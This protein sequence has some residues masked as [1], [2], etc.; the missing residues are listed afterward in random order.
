MRCVSRLV[1][2]ANVVASIALLGLLVLPAGASAKNS[3][4]LSFSPSPFDFGPVT[5]GSSQ[6]KTLTLR[7]AGGAASGTLKVSLSRSDA[8][9]ITT[10][11]CTAR[12]L[13]PRQSCGVTVR[14]AP[15]GA[16]AATATLTAIGENSAPATDVLSGTV[17]RGQ[18]YWTNF[19]GTVWTAGLDG[20]NPTQIVSPE[21]YWL[22]H[23]V[24]VDGSHIY[25]T[26]N[27]N[28]VIWE[29]GLDG[30]NPS[31]VVSALSSGPL[32][33]AVDSSHLYWTDSSGTIWEAGLD[34][35]NRTQIFNGQNSEFGVAVD[36]GHLYWTDNVDGTIWKAGLDG[37][38]PTEIVNG[39]NGPF[40]MAVDS[41][42]LYWTDNGDGTI[43]KAGL[44]GS[45]PTQ[46][47]N[48]QNGPFGMA[49]DSSHLYWTDN[50]DGT[51]WEAG[52]DG[53]NP[54][55][56]INGACCP[57]GVAVRS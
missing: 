38:H 1:N 21:T 54:T 15:I 27:G 2:Y 51:I 56:I 26:D 22:W 30:S 14:F 33:V 49:V 45:N 43:W 19:D 6:S 46:I 17:F 23:Y 28:G 11:S 39:Q 18:L 50:G 29:A 35:S 7:N 3:P 4:A 16:G 24:A 20:S 52:L 40:G 10:D 53:S 44:D 12:S 37:S 9:T 13:G 41:S 48:G 25:W 47:V 57:V 8:F 32:G 34:G 31:Q 5:G 55:Q 36:S 42:H